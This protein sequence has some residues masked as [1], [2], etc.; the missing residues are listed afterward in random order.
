VFDA[1]HRRHKA[2]NAMLY[3]S[4]VWSSSARKAKLAARV[5]A[6]IVFNEHADED[7]G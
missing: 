1:L 3:A 2:S 7:G 4:T 6:G 5:P